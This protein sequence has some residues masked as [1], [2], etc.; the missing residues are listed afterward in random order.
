MADTTVRV[1]V[2]EQIEITES[3]RG[4]AKIW[5]FNEDDALTIYNALKQYFGQ[6]DE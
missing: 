1:K 6:N 2:T 4:V 5:Q 3:G